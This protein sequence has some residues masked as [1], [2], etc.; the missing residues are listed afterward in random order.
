MVRVSTSQ[1]RTVESL[2]PEARDSSPGVECQA[3]HATGVPAG[4][5]SSPSPGELADRPRRSG[6]CSTPGNR[7]RLISPR[8]FR[9]R[10]RPPPGVADPWRRRRGRG[11]SRRSPLRSPARSAAGSSGRGP[12]GGHEVPDVDDLVHAAESSNEPSRSAKINSRTRA[13]W[14][15][16]LMTAIGWV[17]SRTSAWASARFARRTW[18][19]QQDRTQANP[20]CERPCLPSLPAVMGLSRIFGDTAGPGRRTPRVGGAVT[21]GAVSF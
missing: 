20:G 12:G 6:S 18:R 1:I 5:R 4:P 10:N 7:K 19:M 16:V 8:L 17:M 13:P 9:R 2:L 15:P 3:R 11:P 14:P 21:T